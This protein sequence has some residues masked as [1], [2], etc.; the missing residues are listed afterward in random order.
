MESHTNKSND[1][2]S[3]LVQSTFEC[4]QEFSE[5]RRMPRRDFL[6]VAGGAMLGASAI[7]SVLPA[8]RVW[9]K[10][11]SAAAAA[12]DVSRSSPESMVKALYDTLS[13][14]QRENIC[15]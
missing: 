11:K 13:P 2:E 7:G 8:G 5:A 9:A 14:K 1:M 3:K 4:C 12:G 15:F 10:A 6:T